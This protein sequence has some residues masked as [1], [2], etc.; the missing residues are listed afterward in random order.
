METFPGLRESGVEA[1]DR[2]AEAVVFVNHQEIDI[3]NLRVDQ[4]LYSF[5]R[6]E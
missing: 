4:V 3:G 5:E 6:V 2:G 1:D